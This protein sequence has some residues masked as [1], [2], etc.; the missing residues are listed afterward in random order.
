LTYLSKTTSAHEASLKN[1]GFFVPVNFY[2]YQTTIIS[3]GKL[4]TG[5]SNQWALVLH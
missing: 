4:I 3:E 2:N 5:L 1:A